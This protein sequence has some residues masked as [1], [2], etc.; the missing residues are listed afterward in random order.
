MYDG[1]EYKNSAELCERMAAE[2]DTAILAFSTGKDSIAAW[3]QMRK[4]FKTIIPFYKYGIPGLRFV[5][6]SLKY[7]EDF[8]GCHIYR[9]PHPSFLRQLSY[10]VFQPPYRCSEIA[11]KYAIDVNSYTNDDIP[12]IIR[13]YKNLPENVYTG[14][15]VRMADSPLRRTSVMRYGAVIHNKQTF[16]PVYDW[17]KD[18][19]MRELEA[20]KIKLPVDYMLFGRT[21]DGLTYKFLKP[22]KEH[23]PEDYET[24]LKWFPL[25]ELD[26]A[27]FDGFDEIRQTREEVHAYEQVEATKRS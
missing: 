3:L 14:I 9:F 8:F 2:C 10:G 26:I 19:M 15:G 27:R 13:R 18:D 25:A 22:L 5:E 7:Y 4:Y 11:E 23:I 1:L 21:F 17:V 12:R 20:A 6:D 16:Y 24:V